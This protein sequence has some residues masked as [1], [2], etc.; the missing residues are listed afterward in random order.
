MEQLGATAHAIEQLGLWLN[1]HS[2]NTTYETKMNR[3]AV[4]T[5]AGFGADEPIVHPHLKI[6]IPDELLKGIF[7]W[8][9]NELHSEHPHN[10]GTLGTLKLLRSL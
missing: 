4:K 3:E 1:K 10:K 8:V 7:P 5:A 2:F 6:V 9:D